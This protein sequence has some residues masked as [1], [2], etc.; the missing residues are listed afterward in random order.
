MSEQTIDLKKLERKVWTSFFEDGIWDIYL[1]MLLL[2][3]AFGALLTDIG[4]PESSLMIVY[5]VLLGAA[6]VF[7]WVGKRFITLPRVGRV[8]FGPKGKSRIGKAVILMAISALV[9]LLAFV[10]AALSAK[11]SL[12]RSF[13][14]DLLIPGIWVGNM[15][16]VF[17]LAAY[18]LR[19]NR[20]YLIGVMFAIAVPL[21]IV[22][23]VLTHRDL[24]S[25]AFGVPAIT[26]IMMGIFVLSRFLRKYPTTVGQYG[27][28]NSED[29]GA[30]IRSR[31]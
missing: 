15:I 29:Q 31:Q 13:P 4:V 2:A 8:R 11:G 26:V 10:I 17:S 16:I 7:L 22:L 30:S 18:F 9:G 19:F 14:T 5:L 1:G 12:P 3:M 27:E 25:V 24:T 28:A 21:D 23:T 6:M 20:L